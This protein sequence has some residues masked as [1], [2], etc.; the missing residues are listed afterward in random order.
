MCNGRE[1]WKGLAPLMND[2]KLSTEGA[3]GG[4]EERWK[5]RGRERSVVGMIEWTQNALNV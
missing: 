3:G 2:V 4:V 5:K 1:L